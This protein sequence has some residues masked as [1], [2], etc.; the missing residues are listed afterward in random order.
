M[1]VGELIDRLKN[2]NPDADVV[3]VDV[4]FNSYGTEE[5][6]FSGDG[7]EVTIYISQ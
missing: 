5:H 1:T 6:E 3:L 7:E 2:V 4:D